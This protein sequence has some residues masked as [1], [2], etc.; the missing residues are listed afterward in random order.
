MDIAVSVC[1]HKPTSLGGLSISVL[2]QRIYSFLLCQEHQ[3][4]IYL[5]ELLPVRIFLALCL[6]LFR[7]M[8]IMSVLVAGN[9]LATLGVAQPSLIL[10]KRVLGLYVLIR[11]FDFVWMTATSNRYRQGYIC[12]RNFLKNSADWSLTAV[13]FSGGVAVLTFGFTGAFGLGS[14]K[15]KSTIRFSLVRM[16]ERSIL[17]IRTPCKG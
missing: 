5:P 4:A 17:R 12:S 14:P 7:E 1:C 6:S 15:M 13:A 8:D 3:L 9:L 16:A 10:I 2:K 11:V